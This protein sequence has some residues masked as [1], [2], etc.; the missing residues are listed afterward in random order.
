MV[1]SAAWDLFISY[2][3]ADRAWVEGYLLDALEVAGV[4]SRSEATFT[5]GVPRLVEFERAVQQS[6]RTLLIISPAYLADDVT[7]FVNL[8]ALT[9]GL[10]TSTW[11]V[12]P[13]ILKPTPLPARLA[14]LTALDATDPERWPAA[15]ERL[16]QALQVSPP[17]LAP[18]PRC[19]Y[20]GL[21][22]FDDSDDWPFFGRQAEIDDLINRLRQQ[23]YLFVI[24][25]SGSGKS[26]LV[27]A[28]LVTS[29]RQQQSGQWLVRQLRPGSTPI[30]RLA[31]AFGS[32]TTTPRWEMIVASQLAAAAPSQRLL[33][34]VDQLEELFSQAPPAEQMAFIGAIEELRRLPSVAIVL[35]MRADFYPDL[36]N[37]AFWPL[38]SGQ[39][40]EIGALRGEALRQAL[41]EPA[42]MVGVSLEPELVE[43]LLAEAAAEPGALP[44][45]Q[46]TMVLLWQRLERRL[47]T[48]RAYEQLGRGGSG[49]AVALATTADAALARLT[50]AQRAIARRI[51]LDLVQ[52][53]EGRGDTR[54]QQSLAELRQIAAVPDTALFNDTLRIL[55]EHRL[56][57]LSA[58]SAAEASQS[59]AVGASAAD[60]IRQV[61]ISHE[62]LIAAWPQL[63]QWLQDRDLLRM[64][65]RLAQSAAEWQE[66]RMRGQPADG[67]LYAGI[68]LDEAQQFALANAEELSSLETDFLAASAAQEAARERTRY[69]GQAAGLAVGAA[70]GFSLAFL[71]GLVSR[72]GPRSDAFAVAI[73]TLAMFP[74]G[75]VVGFAIGLAL[76][77]WRADSP[78]QRL[79]ATTFASTAA[80]SASYV[81]FL[82][83]SQNDALAPTHLVAGALFGAGLGVAAGLAQTRRQRLLALPLG[84][85]AG[86]LLALATG[87]LTWHPFAT[88]VAGLLLGATTAGGW[89][90]TGVEERQTWPARPATRRRQ[91]D[92]STMAAPSSG[93]L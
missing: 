43:R 88:L 9:Q 18:P 70:F 29:L 78:F 27:R 28:G 15:L 44:L 35:T 74:V 1:D 72:P 60:E 57:T 33:L 83:L 38:T 89:Y 55:A 5:L 90:F 63:Q 81:L 34:I 26:S 79:V 3:E 37:S 58:G 84:G 6:R 93:P 22:S 13:L 50:P 76:W 12:I 21:R 54:R 42:Q 53:G 45:L 17:G 24:G 56:L 48:L 30:T 25:P 32:T 10:E 14:L 87:G 62:A 67:L 49:L 65:R 19:P 16:F 61:D 2:A 52:L 8:L 31:E 40:L 69:L 85:M 20:P 75:Q 71:I 59:P 91:T 80:G 23:N 86:A 73:G 92:S 39:R 41:V 11:K 46:E 51:F 7:Q 66:V 82:R 64:R 4:R 47:L 36:M 77:W 68:R